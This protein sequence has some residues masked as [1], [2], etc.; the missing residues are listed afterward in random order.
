MTR[1][2]QMKTEH[3]HEMSKKSRANIINNDVTQ[4]RETALLWNVKHESVE[5]KS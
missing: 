1:K 5:R 4:A 3:T 2:V